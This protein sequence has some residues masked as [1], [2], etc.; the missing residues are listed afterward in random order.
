MTHKKGDEPCA[1]DVPMNY[2]TFFD[3]ANVMMVVLDAHQKVAMINTKG[4]EV[5]GY[6]MNEIVHKNWFD[7]FLP[8][9]ERKKAE[10]A[11][12]GILKGQVDPFMNFENHI[13]TK[14]G[15][16][17]L[18]RWNNTYLKNSKGDVCY[19]LSS[20]IDIT[21]SRHADEDI[22]LKSALLD[23]EPD[24]IM[25]H[26]DAGHFLYLNDAACAMHGYTREAMMKIP[27]SRI[28]T[29]KH[30]KALKLRLAKVNQLKIFTVESAHIRKDGTVIPVEVHASVADWHG[31]RAILAIVRDTTERGRADRKLRESE[32]RFFAAFHASP[33]LI[34]ITRIS[35]GKILEVNKGYSRMLGY[36]RAESIGKTTAEL[37]IWADPADRAFFVS[38]LK[39]FGKITDFETT[40]RHKNGSLVTVLDSARTIKL[41]DELCTLSVAH[42]ITARKSAEET[43][44][45]NDAEL[46][47]A[48]RIGRIGNFDWD[49][50]TDTI[51]WSDQYYRIYGFKLGQKPPGYKDHLK[52]YTPESA[53]RLD[54]AVKHTMKTGEPYAVDLEHVRTDGTRTWVTA[55]GEVKRDAHRKIIGL[56]GTAQDITQRKIAEIALH[57]LNFQLQA[58]SDC[59]Q[60]LVRAEDEQSLLNSIC[61]IVCE[62]AGYR[63]AWVGFAL[64]DAVKTVS[65]MA[66]SGL[67]TDYLEK[68]KI[69]WD[70]TRLGRGPTGTAIR[71]GKPI[72]NQD[73]ETDPKS[74]PWR[75]QAR[76][77]GYRSSIALPLMGENGKPFGALNIYSAEPKA[78]TPDG[79]RLLEELSNDL[80]FGILSLRNRIQRKKVEEMLQQS[81][82]RYRLIATN[83]SDVIWTGQVLFKPGLPPLARAKKLDIQKLR[84]LI[85]FHFTY[86]SPSVKKS[87]GWT[88]EEFMR[89]DLWETLT[90]E[91]YHLAIQTLIEEFVLESK[92][93]SDPARTRMLSLEAARKDGSTFWI[94]TNMRFLRNEKGQ[95]IGI[96]GINRDITDR[97]K[98]EDELRESRHFLDKIIN[99]IDDPIFV[100]DEQ[101]RW[102]DMNF[103]FCEFVGHSREEL[104]FKS[105][106]DFFPKKQA[107]VF[108]QKDD[109]VFKSNKPVINEEELTSADGKIHTLVTTKTVFT[110]KVSKRKFLV[111]VIHDITEQKKTQSA[112]AQSEAQYRDIVENSP[113]MI[114]SVDA[115]GILFFVNRKE[116]ELLGYKREELIGQPME[117][118]YSPAL[119]KE[120][121]KGLEQLK[122]RG[123]LNIA[124]TQF[125]AKNGTHIDVEMHSIALYDS[126]ERVHGHFVRT[127]SISLDITERTRAEAALKLSEEKYR[128]IVENSPE[129]I[130]SVDAKGKITFVNKRECELLGY[131]PNELIGKPMS[132]VY[133]PHLL[134]KIEAGF[135]KLKKEGSLT[136]SES[137]MIK[138]NGEPLDVEV[139]SIALY[140][141]VGKH[142]HQFTQTRSIIV[143]ITEQK[144]A[145]LELLKYKM[146]IERSSQAIYM[147]DR[148]GEIT[149]INPTFT[150]M[151]GYSEG[152]ALGRTPRILKSGLHPLSF[153]R[154]FWKVLLSGNSIHSEITNKTKD[155]RLIQVAAAANPILDEKNK[156]VGF[157]AIHTDITQQKQSEFALFES[158]N[159]YRTLVESLP[160]CIKLFD[161][162]GKLVSI[163]LHGKEEHGLIGMS[164]E[165]IKNWNYMESIEKEDHDKVRQGMAK[166]MKGEKSSFVIHHTHTHAQGGYCFS[167]LV[168]ILH[169]GKVKNILYSSTDITQQKTN[170][171]ELQKKVGQM[172]F[173]GRV[174]IK[175]YKKM[176][177]LE[178]EIS[179][180]KKRLG[181]TP[182]S[183]AQMLNS[184]K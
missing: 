135:D 174:N 31:K 130:H 120:I 125:V 18:I 35:D 134:K 124:H 51:V 182:S 38:R 66:R 40:L 119:V 77:H 107:D 154:N 44:R 42:D 132:K 67:K 112:L 143:D 150:K 96:M 172:E 29:P 56:R 87:R 76:K 113:E 15:K 152:E 21:D 26:D 177:Q 164:D 79:V 116:C 181:E 6:S 54:A 178:R 175:R 2:R 183:D 37:S 179:E 64:N 68:I 23:S 103:K 25:V 8:P 153:Y 171:E 128:D 78:F 93:G 7:H 127:R 163:N 39:K 168:P 155:G 184:D 49:A 63:M 170:Q 36:T 55:R 126:Q 33:N 72:I 84:K 91:S 129:M 165:E 98:A 151:Y 85:R 169:E 48:Q 74:R 148:E 83:T 94:E 140:D 60:A 92:P 58:I 73:F 157:L 52:A 166:A 97:R 32:E 180:L 30:A 53:A 173:M 102:I 100:K 50:R 156:I 65:V 45:K 1:L 4:C 145:R 158:E 147:T 108:Y 28:L 69:T 123:V 122:K 14:S 139:H 101:H 133:S 117:K 161:A 24:S 59:N 90:P 43:I 110:D 12:R 141:K 99:A 167:T 131:R 159:R 114:H 19:T 9:N 109:Q 89:K 136:I 70:N 46:R 41:Q 61:R 95:P 111:G 10:R 27:L 162:K 71:T 62:K 20:G 47:E 34:A 3:L 118:I 75:D 138:K 104:M 11:W 137:Q 86:V 57:R 144:K 81:E 176:L 17:R 142:R 115:N 146:G 88:S 5:L 22:R 106:Y 82:E 16:K 121:K 13:L 149:Y 105:D 160:A 80:A